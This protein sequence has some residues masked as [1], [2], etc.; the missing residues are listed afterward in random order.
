MHVDATARRRTGRGLDA[1]E[2]H[3]PGDEACPSATV[4]EPHDETEV[5]DIAVSL[6]LHE[7]AIVVRADQKGVRRHGFVQAPLPNLTHPT[8]AG[9][10]VFR[11]VVIRHREIDLAV[12]VHDDVSA[13]PETDVRVAFLFA[14]IDQT[15]QGAGAESVV[16]VQ[17]HHV[18]V[19][20]L[21]SQEPV[22]GIA[23][24]R[25][26]MMKV[27]DQGT[28]FA[29]FDDLLVGLCF[30]GRAVVADDDLA[31]QRPVLHRQACQ[32]FFKLVRPAVGRHKYRNAKSGRN[33]SRRR[34]RGLASLE[35]VECDLL[36]GDGCGR[37]LSEVQYHRFHSFA[38]P[39]VATCD[40]VTA[41]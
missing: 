38:F 32:R 37:I 24:E 12:D 33:R 23:A 11:I 36:G 41:S 30:I 7:A 2:R 9:A 15:G 8:A 39:V 3:V 20:R 27:A 28:Q 1:I 25:R 22:I 18:G 29:G 5:A 35:L 6:A 21:P 16:V 10:V 40:L 34:G 26:R 4:R 31:D 14:R 13:E 19:A 17:E